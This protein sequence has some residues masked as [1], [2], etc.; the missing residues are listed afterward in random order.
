VAITFAESGADFSDM[1]DWFGH[2]DEKSTRIY[3]GHILSRSTQMAERLEGRFGWTA[4]S[5]QAASPKAT[6]G[7]LARPDGT[8][9]V[10][11]RRNLSQAENDQ[12]TS[13][14]GGKR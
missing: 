2:Q 5:V 11:N 12:A 1:R 9:L 6:T 10:K 3:T 7:S 13:V 14:S 8:R 4:D